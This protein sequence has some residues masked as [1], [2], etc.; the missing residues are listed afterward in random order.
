MILNQFPFNFCL[1]ITKNKS[2]FEEIIET[3]AEIQDEEF[4]N[5]AEYVFESEDAIENQHETVR[6]IQVAALFESQNI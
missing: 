2:S 1:K 4:P 6:Q 5:E 3:G